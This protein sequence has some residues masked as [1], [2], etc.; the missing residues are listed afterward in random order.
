MPKKRKNGGDFDT[1][2]I[3]LMFNFL[4]MSYPVKKIK[5]KKRFKRGVDIDGGIYFLPS[6]NYVIFA[7]IFDTLKVMYN[8][9][10]DELK[11]TISRY[12]RMGYGK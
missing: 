11:Y 4:N 9:T 12:Y 5:L 10:D 1:T 7:R 8:T 6:D 3:R 2:M